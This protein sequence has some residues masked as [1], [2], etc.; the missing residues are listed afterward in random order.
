MDAFSR[1]FIEAVHLAFGPF[2]LVANSRIIVF[3]AQERIKREEEKRKK[4]EELD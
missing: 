1:V 4:E 2:V 3:C